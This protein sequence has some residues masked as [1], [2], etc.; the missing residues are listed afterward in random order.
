ML[1]LL[2]TELSNLAKYLSNYYQRIGNDFTKNG[3]CKGAPFLSEPN[4]TSD[5]QTET[6][7]DRLER[8]YF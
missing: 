4:S 1:L 6:K 8:F 7:K 5:P 2:E 3:M